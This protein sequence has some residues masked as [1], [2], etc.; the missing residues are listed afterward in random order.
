MPDPHVMPDL[1]GHLRSP[2]KPG[3]TWDRNRSPVKPGMTWDKPGMTS[4][5]SLLSW[6]MSTRDLSE[7]PMSHSE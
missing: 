1:F 7:S 5:Q 3:M 4:R 6:T 2:V